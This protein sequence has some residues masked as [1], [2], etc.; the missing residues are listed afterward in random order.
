[1]EERKAPGKSIILLMGEF[2]RS[3]VDLVNNSGLPAP[4]SFMIV[5]EMATALEEAATQA[6]N[7][8]AAA[9]EELTKK[10]GNN[11]VRSN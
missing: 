10:E 8:E 1:M 9:Y 2:R 4:I 7:Q 5:K 6:Y 3:L 11:D